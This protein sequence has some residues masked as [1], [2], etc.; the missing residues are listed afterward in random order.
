MALGSVI[1][2]GIEKQQLIPL[3]EYLNAKTSIYSRSWLPSPW[4]VVSWGLR[5][6]GLVNRESGDK[7][8]VGKF[9]VMDNLEVSHTPPYPQSPL[10]T[11]DYSDTQTAAQSLLS[12]ISK[13]AVSPTSNIHSLTTF[14]HAYPRLL[15]ANNAQLSARDT[16][17]LLA[18]LTRDKPT[19]SYDPSSRTI[20]LSPQTLNQPISS[21][22]ISIANLKTLL[23]TLETQIPTLETRLSS[24]E[25]KA[26]EAVAAK[27]T[28]AAKA[29]LR[30]KKLVVETLDKRR[31]NVLQLEEILGKI[32]EA[33]GQVEM[34]RVME[35]SAAV[36][37]NLNKE[38]GGVERVKR[39]TDELR[40]RMADAE[41]VNAVLNEV[42]REGGVDEGEVEDELEAL[43]REEREREEA[44]QRGRREKQ[45]AVERE[46]QRVEDERRA[47]E[48]R[49][50]LA[51]LEEAE[52]RRR[53]AR[54]KEEDEK[55]KEDE[56]KQPEVEKT[57][58][59]SRQTTLPERPAPPD[60]QKFEEGERQ[61]EEPI[62]V[63]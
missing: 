63:S 27:Q 32:D 30:S 50:R 56:Q 37:K 2:D 39:V 59:E 28:S 40:E 42:G 7:L 6:L 48:T 33:H 58:E 55:G 3:D 18:Y 53:E 29:A 20:N 52:R 51:E 44:I 23:L 41:D 60:D 10:S 43:E 22:D 45:E 31:A 21:N 25:L 19:L 24:L 36:L 5:Q 62:P 38:I 9:V 57:T 34:V 61:K 13:T 14:A 54:A 1:Q 8:R 11:A 15:G 16:Q 46:R 4:Q 12:K 35:S 17:I 49:K 26:R 47:E